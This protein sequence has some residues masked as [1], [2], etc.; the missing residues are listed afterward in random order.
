MESNLIKEFTNLKTCTLIADQSGHYCCLNK[1]S[2][3]HG[4]TVMWESAWVSS[5]QV[6]PILLFL[7]R[8]QTKLEQYVLGLSDEGVWSWKGKKLKNL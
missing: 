7:W 5:S 6:A 2:T 1:K 8:E 4:V 3:G